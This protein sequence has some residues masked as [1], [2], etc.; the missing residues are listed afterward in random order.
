MQRSCVRWVF[1][2]PLLLL[3]AAPVWSQTDREVEELF[4]RSVVCERAGEVRLYLE[5]YPAGAYVAEAWACLEQ[6]LGLDRA[7]R[8]LIQQGLTAVGHDPGPVDGLFGAKPSTRTRQA[9]RAWQAAKGMVETGYVTR[10][11]ADVLMAL[12]QE[13][14]AQRGAQAQEADDRAYAEAQRADTAAAYGGYLATYPQGRHAEAAWRAVQAVAE[15]EAQAEAARQAQTADDAAYAQAQRLDTAAAYGNYLAA[16]PQGR[17]TNEARAAQ[18]RAEERQR[19][20]QDRVAAQLNAQMVRVPGGTFTMGCQEGFFSSDSGCDD[21]EQPAHRVEVRSF[22]ISKY[23]VTQELWKVVMGENPSGFK[24]CPQ[25]PVENVS[26]DD[27]QAFLR[28][29]NAGGGRYRLPSE[30]EWEYAARGGSQSRG[31]KYAG[32]DHPNAV[33]WYWDNSGERTHPVG[34]KQVNE[35]GLYDLSGNV[36]E[37][38]QDCWNERY[39]GAPSNGQAWE[40][41]DCSRR[42]LRGG[43][44]KI[45]PR[46]LRSANRVRNTPGLRYND[47]GFRITRSLP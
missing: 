10:E 34:Q 15:R 35:L 36:W 28:E 17:Q 21:D 30:A 14:E 18:A 45:G 41:G 33:A 16:Y 38:V 42:V 31:Y 13:M 24:N 8:R 25:C 43:S 7:A 12:G 39:A 40:R 9:I 19:A 6:Q 26:W 3:V 47:Y 32:S 27:I 22:E 4:W 37:W 46:T 23:E 2:V 1:V 20:A 5:E 29:L 44:W 11:Q